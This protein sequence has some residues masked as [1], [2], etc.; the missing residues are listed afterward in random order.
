MILKTY[1]H[2]GVR[3]MAE[4]IIYMVIS[5]LTSFIFIIIGITQYH[6]AVP[7][8]FYSGEKPPCID[9][10]SDVHS[11]NRQHGKNWIIF[12]IILF[13]TLTVFIFTISLLEYTVVQTILFTVAIGLE[14]VWL[15]ARHEALKR[16]YIRKDK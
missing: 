9:D 6:S 16:K 14:L 5:G 3:I 7:V 11:W 10:V 15:I 2:K 8:G 4:I 1:L 13:A 12:G